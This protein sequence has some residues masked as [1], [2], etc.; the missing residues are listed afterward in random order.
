MTKL[1]ELCLHGNK[2]SVIPPEFGEFRELKKFT[3]ANNLVK[4]VPG[5][6]GYWGNSI[7]EIH[8][9]NNDIEEIPMSFGACWNLKALHLRGNP[10]LATLPKAPA[11]NRGLALVDL[12]DVNP[13][14]ALPKELANHPRCRFLGVKI[15]GKG[16]KR[17]K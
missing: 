2:F 1:E 17:K 6:L 4:K 10:R 7:N 3:I 9:S 11:E 12:R 15:K 14:F 13:E 16:K 8:F 5:Q